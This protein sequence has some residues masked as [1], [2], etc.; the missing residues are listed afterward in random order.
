MSGIYV[1]VVH[2]GYLWCWYGCI[3]SVV[4]CICTGWSLNYSTVQRGV[5]VFSEILCYFHWSHS[6]HKSLNAVTP[7]GVWALVVKLHCKLGMG[8]I[9]QWFLV[10][11]S[12]DYTFR[13]YKWNEMPLF[14]LLS[15][16]QSME[17]GCMINSHLL[18][19]SPSFFVRALC[20]KLTL[21]SICLEV[22][23]VL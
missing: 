17:E 20:C 21:E 14:S 19:S 5:I 13:C 16:I 4:T 12:E 8:L 23:F 6:T 1:K 10:L 9:G 22:C 7:C 3:I 2:W 11:G 18:A 15:C